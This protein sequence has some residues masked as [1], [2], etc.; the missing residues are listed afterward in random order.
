MIGRATLRVLLARYLDCAPGKIAFQYQAAGKPILDPSFTRSN[1]Q[2]NLAHSDDLAL[3]AVTGAGDIGI[4]VERIRDIPEAPELVERFFS[5]READL[6]ATLPPGT[7]AE[8]FFN[9]WTRKEAWLKATGEGI[10]QLL[11]QVEVSFLPQEPA[12]LLGLPGVGLP[13]TRWTLKQLHP[14]PGFAAALAVAFFPIQ[15]RAFAWPNSS[16]V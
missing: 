3:I 2:F 13:L 8:S 14:S 1:L 12:R 5:A 7:R 9:L 6:F 4:D 10:A 16:D 15:I 11:P